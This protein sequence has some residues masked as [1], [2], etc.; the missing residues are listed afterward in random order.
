MVSFYH[1]HGED[2]ISLRSKVMNVANAAE[3]QISDIII[4]GGSATG[5]ISRMYST[6][7]R[8]IGPARIVMYVTPETNSALLTRAAFNFYDI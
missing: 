3:N 2:M 6:P 8:V 4:G 5:Q 7:I 1:K